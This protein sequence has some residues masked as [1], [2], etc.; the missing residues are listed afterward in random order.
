MAYKK[1][2]LY[3]CFVDFTKAFDYITRSALYYKLIKRRILYSM[4]N[5]ATHR[6][7]WKGCMG[8]KIDSEYGVLQGG[9]ASPFLFSEFLY[10]LKEYLHKEYGAVLGDRLLVYLL[11]AD[12]LVLCAESAQDLQKL[13][14]G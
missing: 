5:N 9:M 3:T 4:Y 14:N 10:D 7:K 6:V 1:K 13:L 2:P 8:E 12:D 11:F